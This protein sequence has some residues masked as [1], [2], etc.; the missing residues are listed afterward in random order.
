MTTE[1]EMVNQIDNNQEMEEEKKPA[2]AAKKESPYPAPSIKKNFDL[3][4]SY[5]EAFLEKYADKLGKGEIFDKD[6]LIENIGDCEERLKDIVQNKAGLNIYD[7]LAIKLGLE[8]TGCRKFRSVYA[9][10]FLIIVSL[11]LALVLFNYEIMEN[12]KEESDRARVCF[13]IKKPFDISYFAKQYSDM[14][15]EHILRRVTGTGLS[16]LL[17]MRVRDRCDSLHQRGLYL[18][19]DE[20]HYIALP[21]FINVPLLKIGYFMNLVTL[22]VAL[23]SSNILIFI[24]DDVFDMIANCV[25][26][27]F[28]VE[29]GYYL[30]STSYYDLFE[31][32]L[33]SEKYIAKWKD[34]GKEYKKIKFVVYKSFNKLVWWI[35]EGFLWFTIGF[36]HLS[37]LYIAACY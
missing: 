29:L 1:T 25:I 21:E 10:L 37:S 19:I 33:K 2:M 14:D 26:L 4:I 24:S 8:T 20:H 32:A 17:S 18:S 5:D 7:A 15:N 6:A 11:G 28:L 35:M 16:F 30:V 23:G 13:G 31:E 27:W 36:C 22:A 9:F 34:D 3:W 12:W